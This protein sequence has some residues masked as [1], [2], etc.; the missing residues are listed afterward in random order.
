MTAIHRGCRSQSGR[1]EQSKTA[2]PFKSTNCSHKLKGHC[3]LSAWCVCGRSFL[4]LR[5]LRPAKALLK[6]FTMHWAQPK[7]EQE[8]NQLWENM[9][10]S[11]CYTAYWVC[12]LFLPTL[13]SWIGNSKKGKRK[14]KKHPV[15]IFSIYRRKWLFWWIPYLKGTKVT[16][17]FN[18]T[19][20]PNTQ[21]M[22]SA[23][24]NSD[25]IRVFKNK[26]LTYI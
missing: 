10:D 12:L 16:K 24:C 25:T 15:F 7:M 23:P 2:S 13:S 22:L 4:V 9:S 11:F 20:S 19:L 1:A 14:K 17:N 21:I 3:L 6:S 5:L 18:F 26:I 8:V